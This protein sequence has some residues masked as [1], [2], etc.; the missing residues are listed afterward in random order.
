MMILILKIID[1]IIIINILIL[2]Y[3]VLHTYC[4]SATLCQDT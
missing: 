2:C 3:G 1:V 4:I